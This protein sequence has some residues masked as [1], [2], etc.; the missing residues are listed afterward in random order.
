MSVETKEPTFV[1]YINGEA[2]IVSKEDWE[3]SWIKWWKRLNR[4]NQ[5]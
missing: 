3:G 2:T 4:D 5:N 1:L